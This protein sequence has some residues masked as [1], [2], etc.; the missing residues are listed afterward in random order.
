MFSPSASSTYSR[1]KSRMRTQKLPACWAMSGRTSNASAARRKTTSLFFMMSPSSGTVG[2]TLTEQALR[3]QRQDENEHDEGEDVGVVAAQ[4][5]AGELADVAGAERLDQAEQHTADH[6]ARQV[7]DAAEH[8]R[9]E[10]L[11]TRQK[12]HRVLHRAVGRRVH[13]AGQ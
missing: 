12:A 1:P 10:G 4:H 6:R 13:H 3:A 5:P 11:Q 9:G 7:A 8:R 2:H